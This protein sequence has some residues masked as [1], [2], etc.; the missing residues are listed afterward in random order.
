MSNI[1]TGKMGVSLTQ[2]ASRQGAEVSLLL[3]PVGGIVLPRDVRLRRFTYFE[4]FRALVKEELSKRHY[5][6]LFHAAAVSDFRLARPFTEKLSSVRK[7]LQLGLVPTPKVIDWVCER[8]PR[9]VVVPFKF[10]V[11]I[12]TA[13]LQR[14]ALVLARRLSLRLV[15]ANTFK[16][17]QYL[18][19]IF[20]DGLVVAEAYSR[21]GLARTLCKETSLLIGED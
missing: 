12:S 2:E 15:V 19:F 6:V 16:A 3:G 8:F 13:S 5:D 11:N 10:V 7:K 21:A 14:Q 20:K 17:G 4:E 18:G 9:L 1:S